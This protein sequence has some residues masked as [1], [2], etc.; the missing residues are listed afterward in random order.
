[1]DKTG[2][3]GRRGEQEK[4][5]NTTNR[6]RILEKDGISS[7]LRLTHKSYRGL[8]DMRERDSVKRLRPACQLRPLSVR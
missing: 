8:T 6:E 7:T 2:E 4:E 1:M 3:M 5:A